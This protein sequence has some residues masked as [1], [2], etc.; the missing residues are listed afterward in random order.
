M[1]GN[2]NDSQP[3]HCLVYVCSTA[4]KTKT[5]PK[6]WLRP[7]AG[8]MGHSGSEPLCVSEDQLLEECLQG[9]SKIFIFGCM[10]HPITA[11]CHFNPWDNM[12]KSQLLSPQKDSAVMHVSRLSCCMWD[13]SIMNAPY[14]LYSSSNSNSQL[15]GQF[16]YKCCMNNTLS[17]RADRFKQKFS[18]YYHYR[19]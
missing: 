12:Q 5:C 19:S 13:G 9:L 4:A 1:D 6:T 7:P 2:N 3:L 10:K 15:C 17:F 8:A 18:L 11:Q 14:L 16:Y